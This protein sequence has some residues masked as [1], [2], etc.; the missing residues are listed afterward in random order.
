MTFGIRCIVLIFFCI[1]IYGLGY[2]YHIFPRKFDGFLSDTIASELTKHNQFHIGDYIEYGKNDVLCVVPSYQ[3]LSFNEIVI[4]ERS[5]NF[6]EQRINGF[7]GKS[8]S[9]RW[10]IVFNSHDKGNPR[11]YK[12]T[13]KAVPDFKIAQCYDGHNIVFEKTKHERV[14]IYFKI[15][16]V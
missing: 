8:D 14:Y 6:I 5:K 7:F 13:G 2:Y 9:Y 15:R 12:I 10:I 4:G 1:A 16:E 11:M 3:S